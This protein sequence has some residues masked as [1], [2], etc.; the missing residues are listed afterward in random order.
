MSLEEVQRKVEHF[1]LFQERTEKQ[2]RTKIRSFGV[3]EQE[4]NQILTSLKEERFFDDEHFA[5][6]Y[7]FSK[8][9]GRHWGRLKIKYALMEK[10]IAVPQISEALQKIDED[11]YIAIL[12][13][14]ILGRLQTLKGK[15]DIYNK[16]CRFLQ[17]RGFEMPLI[18]EYV[19]E[20]LKNEIEE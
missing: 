7:V 19:R 16:L 10:G 4:E 3:S 6:Y 1:C 17:A 20:C 11:E 12:Q 5:E 13:K 18:V 9:R 14:A 2:V 15:Q 8:L